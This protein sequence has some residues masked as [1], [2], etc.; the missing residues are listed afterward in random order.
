MS[1]PLIGLIGQTIALGLHLLQAR[2]NWR[3]H[4]KLQ[5][6]RSRKMDCET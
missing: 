3:L 6:N 2:T 5:R 4:K 1:L